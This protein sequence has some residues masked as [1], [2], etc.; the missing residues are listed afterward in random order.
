MSGYCANCRQRL[1]GAYCSHCGQHAHDSA[2][3]V[4]AV[5]HDGWHS[6][7]HVD[8]RVWRTLRL[9]ITK[10]GALTQEFFA[11]RRAQFLPP[12]RLYLI[13]SLLYFA[14]VT[15]LAPSGATERDLV[16]FDISDDGKTEDCRT[17]PPITGLEALDKRFRVACEKIV[18][19]GGAAIGKAFLAYLPK[20]LFA[21]LPLMAAALL[22]F[23]WRPRRIYVEHLVF[24]LHNHAASF[25]VLIVLW[26]VHATERIWPQLESAANILDAVAFMAL[27]VYFYRAMRRFYGQG[28]WLTRAK[29]LAV[30]AVYVVAFTMLMLLT[31]A[32]SALSLS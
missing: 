1:H 15:L 32:F 3:T 6:F 23:Y 19:S 20:G 30:L 10:P 16:K 14:L 25:L 18:S 13:L 2:R 24:L 31:L 17:I 22:L 7:T 26:V 5:F 4:G 11:N 21:F 8:H 12:F 27:G 28:A 9:L 29:Y